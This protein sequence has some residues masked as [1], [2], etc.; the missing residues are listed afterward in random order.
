[1]DFDK[2]PLIPA[3]A[4]DD[5]TG[6]VLM[7]AHMNAESLRRILGADGEDLALDSAG[8]ICLPDNLVKEAH[9]GKKVKLVGLLLGRL[10]IVMVY[11]LLLGCMILGIMVLWPASYMLEWGQLVL[12][13][14][15]EWVNI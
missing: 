13:K 12:N 7:V 11:F 2:T 6:E 9:L 4:Q 1:M 5:R 3:I 14:V 15:R 8:R 10:L